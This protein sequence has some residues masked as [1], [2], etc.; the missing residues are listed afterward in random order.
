[1]LGRSLQRYAADPDYFDSP[2]LVVAVDADPVDIRLDAP[3]L[4]DRLFLGYQP[5]SEAIE[6]I[7]Y[8]EAAGRFEFQ[9][10]TDYS[11][12]QNPRVEYAVRGI[13]VTCHQSHAPIF[14]RPL[15]SESN[16]NPEIAARLA[17]LG[18]QY[19]GA[20][21]R[22]GVDSLDDIDQSTDRANRLSTIALLW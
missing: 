14:S 1:P 13:C 9:E 3:R 16:G 2:R 22:Q 12:G 17:G 18:E 10:I 15:W 5:A 6:V 8:N 19:H 11:V 20:P 7:S 4:K 21:V